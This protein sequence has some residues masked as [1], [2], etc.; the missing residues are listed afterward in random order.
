MGYQNTIFAYNSCN[1]GVR[2]AGVKYPPWW[3][4][5]SSEILKKEKKGEWKKEVGFWIV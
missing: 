2:P 1:I 4:C 5:T 3:V